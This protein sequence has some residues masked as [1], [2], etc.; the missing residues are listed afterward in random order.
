MGLLQSTAGQA[1]ILPVGVQSVLQFTTID[2][3]CACGRY[4]FSEAAAS[5]RIYCFLAILIENTK[6]ASII[7]MKFSVA[8]R[9]IL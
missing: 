1:P 8:P 5:Q 4:E 3:G 2:Q 6:T 9:H 7:L